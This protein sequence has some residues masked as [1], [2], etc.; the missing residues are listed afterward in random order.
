MIALV[1]SLILVQD[2]EWFPEGLAY[3]HPIADPRAPVTGVRFQFPV[4]RDD[5]FKNESVLATHLS[6]WRAGDPELVAFEFQA[7]GAAFGRFNFSENWDMDGVDFRFGFPIVS[8]AGPIALKLHPWHITS[9]LGDEFIE[10]TGRKRVV[11]AR[12]EIALGIS[13]DIDPE[14]RVY[15]EVGYA[16]S[17]GDVNEPLR[18]M[19]GVETVGRH[20]GEDWP[21]TYAALNL[22][23]IEEQDYG[24]Q[25]NLEAGVWFRPEK[26]HRGVRIGLGYFRGPSA[27]TQ[28]F[29]DNEEYWT[30]GFALPF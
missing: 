4:D 17:R 21:E 16:P 19:A 12:N 13:W 2:S 8:R 9:H 6:L 29:D 14:W 20:F 27:L 1:F 28:F 26:T 3:R 7:E 10:R 30:T 11:Y 25:L 5:D 24:I 18:Y 23:S 22:T 15:F